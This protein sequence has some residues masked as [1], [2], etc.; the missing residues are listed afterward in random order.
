MITTIISVL[1]ILGLKINFS[2]SDYMPD[3]SKSMTAIRKMSEEFVEPI[4][5]L[6][7][8]LKDVSVQEALEY[9]SEL[10]KISD[11]KMVLWLDRLQNTTTPVEMI[12]RKILDQF[13]KDRVALLQVA[14]E[15]DNAKESLDKIKK[16]LPE[17][18]AYE[19]E[20]VSQASSQ[21]AVSSE[22]ST[23]TVLA[24]PASLLILMFS[25]RSY[26]EPF[27]LLI[28]IGIA[29]VINMGTNI[30]LGKIS[31][32]TQ[33]VSSI[34]Q[35]AVSLDYAIFLLH[36]YEHQNEI[37]ENKDEALA[38][39][40]SISSSA[41]ISS[42]LTTVFGFLVLVFMKFGIG[43][44]LGLV[45]AK[46]VGLSLL[47]VIF[48]LPALIKIFDKWIEKTSH[49]DLMPNFEGVSKV[50]VKYRKLLFII[51][52]II[53]IAYI[54][55][56]KNDFTYGMGAYKSESKEE[57][58]QKFIE[59][60]F[61]ENL[62]VV[63][64]VPRGELAKE[65]ELIEELKKHKFINSVQSYTEQ[66]STSI[67]TEIAPKNQISS[68]ISDKYSR[69]ILNTTSKREG[70]EAFK[71]VEFL[72]ET[73]N[74]FYS[75][76]ELVG[77]PIVLYNMREI[78]TKDNAIVNLLAILA[79][80][81]IIMINFK[82]ISIPIFLVLTIQTSIWINLS[83]PYFSDTQ[84]SFIGYLIISSIQL[85]ATVDYAILYTS[86]YLNQRK[87]NGVKNAL[88]KTGTKVYGSI[89]PPALILITAGIILSI[90]S[91]ISLVSELGTVLGRGAF[92][93]LTMVVVMLPML[94]YFTDKIIEVTTF[95][96]NFWKGK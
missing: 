37:Y 87:E 63:I 47:S 80:G 71:F 12:D 56:S 44:D 84:L 14:V 60:T 89:I 33:S 40:V 3:D 61:G 88:I 93:S 92:L 30:F 1:L 62:Q 16:V 74:K 5:N 2:L 45:L 96:S 26:I 41:V 95:N 13:Y 59:E 83:I 55:Q 72:D 76:F 38:S 70:E 73:V 9:K 11:I 49:R 90:V 42:A 6:R 64:L 66:V 21:N 50:V 17:N 19:G 54:G 77:E 15:T 53:P 69:I 43:K 18:T 32:V 85:G 28:C 25:V 8:A 23:I 20:I 57:M 75:D 65:N 29:V 35:M 52:L 51:L 22:I 39:A 48:T 94:I 34:L 36:E 91:S 79:V 67:P 10:E 68:L 82:S 4:P 7:I 81:I 86:E 24:V 27:L 58:D 78:I 46:G 31:F